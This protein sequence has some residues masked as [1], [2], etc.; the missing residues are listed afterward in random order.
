MP[1]Q[2]IVQHD[3]AE[4]LLEQIEHRV[5]AMLKVANEVQHIIKDHAVLDNEDVTGQQFN[6]KKAKPKNDPQN[7]PNVALVQNDTPDLMSPTRWRVEQT[8]LTTVEVV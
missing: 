8:D 4:R 5:Q 2:V 3:L 7:L 1:V 6:Q